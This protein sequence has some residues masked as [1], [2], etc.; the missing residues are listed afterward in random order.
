MKRIKIVTIGGGS[1][2]TPELAEG[3]IKRMKNG[4]LDIK[5][6]AL[7]DIDEGDGP[8]KLRIIVE[9]VQ[10]MF[11]KEGLDTK[12]WG[13]LDR[14]EA[15]KDGADFVT[16]QLR[17]GR[18]EARVKDER[19]PLS[20]GFIGQE[21]NGAGGL[22]KALRTIPVILSIVEDVKK[23]ANGAWIINFTNPSGIVTQAIKK[24]GDY[25]K[26]IGVCNVPINTRIGIADHFDVDYHDVKYDVA[27][28]NH[29]VYFSRFWV[30]DKEVTDEVLGVAMNNMNDLVPKNVRSKMPDVNLFDKNLIEKLK[31]LPCGYHRYYYNRGSMLREYL[32]Q[33]KNNTTR[34]EEVMKIEEKLFKQYADPELDIKP[35][36]LMLRGGAWYSEVACSVVEAIH[37]DTGAEIVVSTINNGHIENFPNGLTSESTCKITKDGALPVDGRKIRIPEYALPHVK[38]IKEFEL[39]AVEA[40]MKHDSEIGLMALQINPLSEDSHIARKVFNELVDAHKKYLNRFEKI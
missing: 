18:M 39:L 1:S 26:F 6:W 20:N 24:H 35:P 38:L 7:V 12:I 25:E 8:K 15:L 34:A 13:T 28:L 5:E 32:E 19:I 23:Y 3:F 21:T 16:T 17:V 36:E 2:Y 30:K 40:A 27:G 29:F 37:N 22:F 31:A 9:L 4:L 10:R 11:K 33:F 14:K